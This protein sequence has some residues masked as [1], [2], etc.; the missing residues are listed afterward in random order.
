MVVSEIL[1][2]PS[3]F[4]SYDDLSFIEK[5]IHDTMVNYD[6][7]RWNKLCQDAYRTYVANPALFDYKIWR[8]VHNFVFGIHYIRGQEKPMG[9]TPDEYSRIIDNVTGCIIKSM[10]EEIELGNYGVV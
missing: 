3:P 1:H 10:R 4:L 5:C 7:V 9:C 8:T 2:A 6:G